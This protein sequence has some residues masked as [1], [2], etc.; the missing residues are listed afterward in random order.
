[1]QLDHLKRVS[2]GYVFD[3]LDFLLM[4]PGMKQ[5][6]IFKLA[7][8]KRTP[9]P[10]Q[11][12]HGR[13]HI[14]RFEMLPTVDIDE[15]TYSGNVQVINSALTYLELLKDDAT[16][17]RLALK[18]KIPWTGDQMTAHCCLTAQL[19]FG[20]CFNP[21]DRLEPFLFYYALFHCEMALGSGTYEHSRGTTTGASTLAR[22]ALL[23]NRTGLNQNMNKNRP[24]FHKCDEA[25]LHEL[26]A[27]IR[28]AFLVESGCQSDN[29]MIAWADTH[30]DEEIRELATRVYSNHASAAGLSKLKDSGSTDESR[31][32][33]IMT[34]ANILRYYSFWRA[35]KHGDVNRIEDLLPELL[36]FFSGSGNSNYAK[37][38]YNFLQLLRHEVPPRMKDALLKYG[39]LVNLQGRED[40][41]Y[42]IDQRQERNN[43]GIRTYAPSSPSSTWMHIQKISPVIPCYM[44][45]VKFVEE[46]I[47]GQR[48]SNIHKDPKWEQDVQA[49]IRLHNAGNIH[50]EVPGRQL[51]KDDVVKDCMAVGARALKEGKLTEYAIKRELYFN[52][53]SDEVS[54]SNLPSPSV[55]RPPML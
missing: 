26:E 40:S 11:L 4:I 14:T 50:R 29:K 35:I 43:A 32:L 36:I 24:D 10:L 18:Q 20:E 28:G 34:T 42:P 27:R 30:T 19:F 52:G 9:G 22:S 21:I 53:I 7:K 38:T 48:C 12:P 51:N 25:L 55:S 23:L 39:L 3:V 33:T 37:E 44:D 5:R 16:Q 17:N 15:S 1:M 6:D 47:L 46:S 13:E 31:L 45:T 54:Y 49:L 41:F 8:L 2:S